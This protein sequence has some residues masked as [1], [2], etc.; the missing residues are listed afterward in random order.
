MSFIPSLK[1]LGF[2]DMED[3]PFFMM[4]EAGRIDYAGHAH[5]PVAT[6]AET[7]EMDNIIRKIYD[8]YKKHSDET[9]IVVTSDHETGGLSLGYHSEYALNLSALKRVNKSSESVLNYNS[10]KM[11]L[12]KLYSLVENSFNLGDL[13]KEEMAEIKK[14]CDLQNSGVSYGPPLISVIVGDIISHRALL[15]WTTFVHTASPV[16]VTADGAG[17]EIFEGFYDNTDIPK[18]IAKISG[19]K[20]D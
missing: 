7:L 3:K 10:C 19:F 11:P 12:T 14:G 18:K 4:V 16:P 9:L 15:G 17:A 20:L 2:S 5:D 1:R 13:T 8:F 6:I